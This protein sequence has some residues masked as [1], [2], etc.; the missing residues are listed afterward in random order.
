MGR[1]I[2]EDRRR[3]I[4]KEGYGER[5]RISLSQQLFSQE[6]WRTRGRVALFSSRTT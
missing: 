1:G 3:G 4:V 6:V 2:T 5:V